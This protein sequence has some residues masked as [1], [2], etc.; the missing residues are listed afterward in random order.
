MV[1]KQKSVGR[2]ER[3]VIRI[4]FQFLEEQKE[5]KSLNLT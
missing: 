1:Q 2:R 5:T 4:S 3:C